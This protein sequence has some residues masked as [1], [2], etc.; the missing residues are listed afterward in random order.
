ML[1]GLSRSRLC[2]RG[3]VPQCSPRSEP[4]LRALARRLSLE[5]LSSIGHR[6]NAKGQ[7]KT[8][9]SPASRSSAKQ[10]RGPQVR[11]QEGSRAMGKK[12]TLFLGH[13]DTALRSECTLSTTPGPKA[14]QGAGRA[15]LTPHF[16]EGPETTWV[17]L[18]KP[19]SEPRPH[20]ERV[21]PASVQALPVLPRASWVL[22]GYPDDKCVPWALSW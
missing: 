2:P 14:A 18:N 11:S 9:P 3:P 6:P 8:Q 20:P 22:P 21:L 5:C 15:D 19:G 12:V 17:G 13:V 4:L 10:K 16:T 1:S 7:L